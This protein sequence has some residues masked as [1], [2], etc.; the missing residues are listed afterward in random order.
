MSHPGKY[1]LAPL[2]PWTLVRLKLSNSPARDSRLYLLQERR[3]QTMAYSETQKEQVLKSQKER[4]FVRPFFTELLWDVLGKHVSH[5]LWAAAAPLVQS[6]NLGCPGCLKSPY[7]F[8]PGTQSLYSME[9]TSGSP[10][11]F[12]NLNS[13]PSKMNQNYGLKF[14]WSF[15]LFLK[16]GD[17]L[18]GG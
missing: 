13:T 8:V 18:Q 12:Q 16:K 9:S 1:L 4:P 10:D 3:N 17:S 14:W 15:L 5:P 6:P 7:R 11:W 2:L